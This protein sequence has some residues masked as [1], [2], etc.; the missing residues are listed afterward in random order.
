M[1][2]LKLKILLLSVSLMALPVL[3]LAI[4]PQVEY[5][6]IRGIDLDLLIATDA[7]RIKHIFLYAYYALVIV[8]GIVAFGSLVLGGVQWF[9]YG[10][11]VPAAEGKPP[12]MSEAKKRVIT[13]FVGLIILL[14]SW[15]VLNS[16]DPK[17]LE[18]PN[19]S[20]EKQVARVEKP[21]LCPAEPEFTDG[22]IIET[23]LPGFREIPMAKGQ[24][25]IEDTGKFPLASIRS[26][27]VN[28][29]WDGQ[30]NENHLTKIL[31]FQDPIDISSCQYIVPPSLTGCPNT[32][33]SNCDPLYHYGVLCFFETNFQNIRYR[34]KICTSQLGNDC[35][36][37]INDPELPCQSML[38]FKQ[39]ARSVYK[40]NDQIIFYDKRLAQAKD[41]KTGKVEGRACIKIGKTAE[42]E[43]CKVVC[44]ILDQ[45][46]IYRIR[47]GN[48]NET[49]GCELAP[50]SPNTPGMVGIEGLCIPKMN[51]EDDTVVE[52]HLPLSMEIVSDKSR[53]YLVLVFKEWG[54]FSSH[55]NG[56]LTPSSS[57]LDSSGDITGETAGMYILTKD[58][59]AFD[60][61]VDERL[62]W[63]QVPNFPRLAQVQ[64]CPDEPNYKPASVL[65]LPLESI[66][67]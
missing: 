29:R 65:I 54:I 66:E 20:F 40:S 62:W 18:L 61:T 7:I 5:P 24:P 51:E 26:V 25:K 8:G 16:I 30:K 43:N 41:I 15:I 37:Y 48:A 39:P 33:Y 55:G 52:N 2:I 67:E 38:S 32:F 27:D 47:R 64:N 10:G 50:A 44:D 35:T 46:G 1:P 49:W 12:Q 17:L 19:L 56:I 57:V 4:V 28:G 11:M 63:L 21:R 22:Y 34:V 13:S 36:L 42:P 59:G 9:L 6:D 58:V 3:V 14:S 45:E 23:S 53:K 31:R 60:D